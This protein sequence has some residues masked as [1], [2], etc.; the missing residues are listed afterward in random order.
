MAQVKGTFGPTTIADEKVIP[1]SGRKNSR[2][3]NDPLNYIK[4]SCDIPK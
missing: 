1:G 2:P 4:I 3:S